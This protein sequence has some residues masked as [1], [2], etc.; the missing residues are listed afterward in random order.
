ML[1]KCCSIGD[2]AMPPRAAHPRKTKEEGKTSGRS[3]ALPMTRVLP[4]K[5]LSSVKICPLSEPCCLPSAS[6][7]AILFPYVIDRTVETGGN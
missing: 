3:D 5:A 4:R 7:V 2:F 6:V 1:H